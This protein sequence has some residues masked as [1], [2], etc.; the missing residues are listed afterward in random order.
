MFLRGENTNVR[1]CK[2]ADVQMCKYANVQSAAIAFFK[3]LSDW[4]G[5]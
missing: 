4:R 2:C 3:E 1:M 5:L